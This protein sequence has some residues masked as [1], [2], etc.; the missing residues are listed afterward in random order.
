MPRTIAVEDLKVGMF[1]RLDL[2]WLKHPFPLSRF[3]IASVEQIAIIRG[4]G[5][6][7]LSW[8]PEK[9]AL[10]DPQPD[11]TASA[12]AAAD[13]ETA[14]GTG[15][16]DTSLQAQGRNPADAAAS[17]RARLTQERAALQ[18]SQALYDEA[19]KV[20]QETSALVTRE[21]RTAAQ[22]AQALA[23]AMLEKMLVQGDLC[24]RLLSAATSDRVA[25]HALN[26]TVIALLMGR[27]LGLTQ[28]E[29]LDLGTGALLHDV[30]KLD[31]PARVHFPEDSFGSVELKAYRDHVALGIAR[32]RQMEL[33]PGA[34]AVLAQH[35]EMAD[36]SGF[37]ERL[38]LDAITPA[39]RLV[40]LVNRYDNLCNPGPRGVP[41]TPHEAIS[42]LF[43]QNRG[44]FDMPI[45][46]GFI[47]MMG[48][49]PPGSVVQLTDDRY[50]LVMQVN[51]S[52][53]L[54]PRVLVHDVGVPRD[55]ALLLDLEHEADLGIRR[56]LAPAKLPA[57]AAS[58]LA[59]HARVGYYFDVAAQTP[60]T[61]EP[62]LAE[63]P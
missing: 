35:H 31:L 26:V 28:N 50:A 56:S 54:K 46:N 48:I 27:A 7:E 1:I 43:A 47:R 16:A 58:Y 42:V 55:E 20:L 32:G 14:A 49:Y 37:P 39:A 18:H 25:A 30:G 29:L 11:A 59:P 61:R 57:A 13:G 12:Q 53:P 9:S 22:Q 5:L 63:A 34:L 40:A 21:P 2:G 8:Y 6:R 45:L 23:G 24:V 44:R 52:R 17:R 62:E 19:A 15:G 4:L 36:G 60:A 51:A 10:A 33:A 38:A 3:R 41:L